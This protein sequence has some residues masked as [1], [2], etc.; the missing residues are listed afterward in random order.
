MQHQSR[1]DQPLAAVLWVQLSA[2]GLV[3]AAGAVDVAAACGRLPEGEGPRRWFDESLRVLALHGFLRWQDGSYEVVTEQAAEQ[4]APA[5]WAAW[6]ACLAAP[7]VTPER[8]IARL[9]D[10]A[11]KALPE[12]LSGRVRATDVLF[13]DG[14][15][16]LV[17]GVYR[18]NP[19]VDYFNDIVADLCLTV[20]EGLL[21]HDP[22][23][24]PRIIEIGAGTGGTTARVLERL[25]PVADRIEDYCFTDLSQAFLMKARE[26]FGGTHPFLSCRTFNVEVP[27]SDQKMPMD[28]YDIAIA[29]N[30]IHATR[31][32]AA[33]LRTIKA[34]LRGNGVL[35]INEIN[36]NSLAMHVTFGL[37][38]GWW[39]YEDAALRLPGC[40]ALA[41]ESW[42]QV[43][44]AEGYRSVQFPASGAA[45]LGQQVIV[46][47]SDGRVRRP[48]QRAKE[49]GRAPT[50]AAPTLP[51]KSSP[52]QNRTE[53]RD[54]LIALAAHHLRMPASDIDPERELSVYDFDSIGFTHYAKAIN[55]AFELS[56]TPAVFYENLDILSLCD[57]LLTHHGEAVTGRIRASATDRPVQRPAA[58]HTPTDSAAVLLPLLIEAVSA[59][60]KVPASDLDPQAELSTYGFDSIGFTNLASLI[61]QR[62]G[63]EITPALFYESITLQS[64]CEHLA[65][66]Y[67]E[68]IER[69]CRPTESAGTAEPSAD[70]QQ[71]SAN[72]AGPLLSA[73]ARDRSAVRD[74]DPVAIIGM[75]IKVPECEDAAAFW[76]AISEN[77]SCISEIPDDRWDW[78]SSVSSHL[79]GD[80]R[81][82]TRWGGFIDGIR[83][84]DAEFFGLSPDR[85]KAMD[86]RIRLLLQATWNAIE[87]AG[88]SAE[89]LAGGNV[90]SYVGM[91]KHDGYAD[92]LR[93][94]ADE[95]DVDEINVLSAFSAA[96]WLN[97]HFDFNGPSEVVESA[98]ASGIVAL[99]KATA[100]LQ[101]RTCDMAIVGGANA[102]LTPEMHSS[103]GRYGILSADGRCK[104]FS[105][106]ADGFVRSEGVGVLVLKRALEA[107]AAGD[108]IYGLVL[109]TAQTH[110]GRTQSP[111]S[112]NTRAQT[113]AITAAHKRA[114]V[115][116]DS[117]TYVEMHG[118]GTRIGDT[119]EVNGLKA[120][121]DELAQVSA[122]GGRPEGPW[123]GLGSVKG[124]V[125]H[126]EPASGI[127]SVVKVLQQFRRGVLIGNP[128]TD[129]LNPDLQLRSS[130]F[131]VLQENAPWTRI[132]DAYGAEI[133]RRAGISAFGA[134]GV[135]AHSVLQEHLSATSGEPDD[136]DLSGGPEL[137]VLSA[138]TREQLAQ[139][140]LQLEEFLDD[141]DPATIRLEDIAYTLQF[142]RDE[143]EFRLGLRATS[144]A[145]VLERIRRYLAKGADAAGVFE[146]RANQKRRS[147]RVANLAE[148]SRIG[149]EGA[150]ADSDGEALLRGWVNGAAVNWHDFH[151]QRRPRRL[152]LPTYPFA[153]RRVWFDGPA[154]TGDRASPFPE[155]ILQLSEAPAE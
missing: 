54:Q 11:L 40:P 104:T 44:E 110:N 47:E 128:H 60:A 114:G 30:V 31:D 23:Y 20:V 5:A 76:R 61:N 152:A 26:R 50:A 34:P 94:H 55:E 10:H 18:G 119:I 139:R 73:V 122:G 93:L 71:T 143:M 148:A 82:S 16:E 22:A 89:R 102:L 84:F 145:E 137:I 17:E 109:G 45:H 111:M 117:V 29:T 68:A 12:I 33:S 57:H 65:N 4:D 8:A 113:R 101:A 66:R 154:S 59:Y 153:K 105:E 42:R 151:R 95:V 72:P 100:A 91:L 116:P 1:M 131:Y 135:N 58:N 129:A 133:P 69:V 99:D 103:L 130:P 123:C 38:D 142:G 27:A 6:S 78:Q 37:L 39:C 67:P 63:V 85:A 75:S 79:S 53:L 81:E 127:I 56:L 149:A 52:G 97:Y 138:R 118:T 7:E 48:A 120:A 36:G 92:L 80:G 87:D 14:S 96:N 150:E 49:P 108:H 106:A 155:T 124:N 121:F 115:P 15:Q 134:G 46:A 146:G 107:E 136:P 77:R 70:V 35:L 88:Y 74:S 132:R 140:V 21:E 147:R 19:A 86:P 25:A 98:C 41:P 125:G 62:L 83:E 43:L 90:A 9:A 24:R 51:T 32:I 112:P 144:I 2:A 126:L 141:A 13:P 3:P 28:H 64:V